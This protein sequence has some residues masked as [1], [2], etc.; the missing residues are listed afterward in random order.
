MATV[1]THHNL[2]VAMMLAGECAEA[3]IALWISCGTIKSVLGDS[4][5]RTVTAE[6]N[7]KKARA[8]AQHI[9]C[10]V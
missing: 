8:C 6:G 4:H 1:T 7:L 5:P 10:D 3:L 9:R 2:G